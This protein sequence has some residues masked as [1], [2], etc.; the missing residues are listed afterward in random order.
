MT[1]GDC[2]LDRYD[3]P[4]VLQK[5][6]LVVKAK[7]LNPVPRAP[8]WYTPSEL[9]VIVRVQHVLATDLSLLESSD[10][11]KLPSSFSKKAREDTLRQGGKRI[12]NQDHQ[13]MLGQI[14]RNLLIEHE[15]DNFDDD[16][17]SDTDDEEEELDDSDSDSE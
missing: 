17:I 9:E 5:G 16:D 3:G 12:S 4:D 13:D 2:T 7:Y 14:L 8:K 10:S 6:E 11:N 15:E 1:D